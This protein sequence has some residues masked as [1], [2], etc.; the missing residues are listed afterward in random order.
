[1]R[2]LFAF[3]CA[4]ALLA[5]LAVPAIAEDTDLTWSERL[6]LREQ[7]SDWNEWQLVEVPEGV[8][9]V[10]KDIPVGLWA[11]TCET[12]P[13]GYIGW[14]VSLDESGAYID[15]FSLPMDDE[16]VY[17]PEVLSHEIEELTTYTFEAVEGHYVV[18]SGEPLTFTIPNDTVPA[19]TESATEVTQNN[20]FVSDYV[21]N[22]SSGKIHI[23][24][25]SCAKSVKESNRR[26]FHC[27]VEELE[28]MGY[29]RCKR[30]W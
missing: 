1:M 10:G 9:V 4:V 27:T 20:G 21:V 5:A 29:V 26:N 2:K 28:A 23:A 12:G 11:V 3:L 17:N 24:G 30:C 16:I 14:G 25:R 22:V 6:A 7:L 13:C 8:W 18:V 19:T 15:H